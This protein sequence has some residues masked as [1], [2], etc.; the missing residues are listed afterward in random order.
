MVLSVEIS[1]KGRVSD[2]FSIFGYVWWSSI[3]FLGFDGQSSRMVSSA[4]YVASLEVIVGGGGWF[5]G[6]LRRLGDALL[7]PLK[8]GELQWS[9]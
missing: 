7:I 2:R 6:P 8:S 9:F 4:G 5:P 1:F 3:T